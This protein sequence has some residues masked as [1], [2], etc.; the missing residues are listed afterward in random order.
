V[1]NQRVFDA[2]DPATQKAVLDAAATA[3]KR[4]WEMAESDHVAQRKVL[5]E[6]GIV[7]SDGSPALNAALHD[8]GKQMAAEWSKEAGARGEAVLEAYRAQ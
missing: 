2:L 7:V 3:E 1:V 5:Q 8:I 4:G 6:N